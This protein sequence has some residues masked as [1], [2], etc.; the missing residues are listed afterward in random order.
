[1]GQIIYAK[2]T[3]C[4]FEKEFYIGGGLRDCDLDT[5]LQSLPKKQRDELTY[6]VHRGA[7]H[8]NMNRILCRCET[9]KNLFVLPVVNF[10]L[11]DSSYK[12]YGDCE[13][14]GGEEYTE[15]DME[16]PCECPD[17]GAELI[18]QNTGHWD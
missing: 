15:I 9:C 5:M 17:C 14:C 1:M 11:N 6:A 7:K 8:I 18:K 10:T 16:K 13:H 2:C 3:Q 4:D 12:L